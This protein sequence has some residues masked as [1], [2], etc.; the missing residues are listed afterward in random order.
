[1]VGSDRLCSLSRLGFFSSTRF[2]RALPPWVPASL[3]LSRTPS[4]FLHSGYGEL[5]ETDIC[6]TGVS[7]CVLHLQDTD[8][9][10][11]RHQLAASASAPAPAF[12][13][14]ASVC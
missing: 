9:D 12:T 13:A 8:R 1:M 7:R 14:P 5:N 4:P 2:F 10:T 6:P 3:T 11:M